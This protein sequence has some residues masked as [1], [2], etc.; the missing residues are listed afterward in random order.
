MV[1]MKARDAWCLRRFICATSAISV[2]CFFLC[3]SYVVFHGIVQEESQYLYASGMALSYVD[4]LSK[5]T[6]ERPDLLMEPPETGYPVYASLL[7]TVSRWN[8]DDPEPPTT[9]KETIQRFNYSDELER[10]YAEKFR[11]AEL[12]F[13]IYDI[14]NVLEVTRKWNDEYL[15][16]KMRFVAAHVEE[17][18]TNHFMYWNG[19]RDRIFRK[20]V[21]PTDIIT[22]K[23]DEW[24]EVA[25]KADE[26]KS[27]NSTT[28]YYFMT[29]VGAGDNLR[30]YISQ[31]LSIFS[32]RKNNFFVSNVAANKGIQCR[33][34]MRGII[35]EAHFDSGRNMVAMIKGAKRYILNPP[36]ECKKLGIISDVKHPSY[37]HSVID[38]SDISQATSKGFDSVNAIDT[39]VQAGE[40]LY[41][42]SYWFHYIVS[43][44]Y[45][46]QCNSRSGSPPNGEGQ[47]EIEECLGAVRKWYYLN[48]FIFCLHKLLHSK[49]LRVTYTCLL[50]SYTCSDAY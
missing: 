16:Q 37:R 24:L 21:P 42:P 11:N 29:G 44:Q 17:S 38:W 46:V 39:I 33:F 26:T 19:N 30:S 5:T 22:M 40:V 15:K 10:S 23:F 28:H 3:Y 36:H 7:E 6:F 4:V 2:V 34:G 35:A 14:P 12:P 20:Y 9:F 27:T 41:I 25:K 32:S 50:R 31:D 48:N 49:T 45:S 1:N 43:L 8:P 18:K 47:G 13:K